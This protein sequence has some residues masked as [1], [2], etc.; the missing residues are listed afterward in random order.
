MTDLKIKV[1]NEYDRI[2]YKIGGGN[3]S[4]RSSQPSTAPRENTK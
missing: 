3:M 4:L 1:K 2:R